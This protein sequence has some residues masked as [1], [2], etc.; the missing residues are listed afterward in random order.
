MICEINWPWHIAVLPE[1]KFQTLLIFGIFILQYLFEHVLPQNKKYNNARH[2][3]FNFLIGIANG[4]LLFIP[5]ALLVQLLN[6]IDKSNIGLL[7]QVSLPLWLNIG[8]TILAM[9]FLMYWWHRYNHTKMFFWQFHKFHHQEE[10]MNSTTALRF[11]SI[12]LLFSVIGK[13]VFYLLSGFSFIP[14][15][16]YET[17]FFITVVLH[18]SNIAVS[19]KFDMAYRQIFSSPN[20]HRIHHSNIQQ[21]TDSNYGSVFSWWDRLFGTYKN[22]AAGEI[23]FGIDENK[24]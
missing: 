21:E 4:L 18:H 5:S 20:M 7:Q 6:R 19:K 9:D 12:E 8:I 23:I 1:K 11:H 10:K 17:L 13:A 2:E 14:I 16:I 15:L 24:K 3:G 22:K